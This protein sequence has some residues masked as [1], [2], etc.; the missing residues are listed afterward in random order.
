M[1]FNESQLGGDTNISSA[2]RVLIRPSRP[3]DGIVFDAKCLGDIADL[4]AFAHLQTLMIV[5]GHWPQCVNC[6][7]QRSLDSDEHHFV[8]ILDARLEANEVREV[9]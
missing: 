6:F 9:A 4:G 7:Y 3:E 8:W 2:A 5:V 1:S